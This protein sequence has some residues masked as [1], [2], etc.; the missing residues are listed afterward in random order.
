MRAGDRRNVTKDDREIVSKLRESLLDKVGKERFELW[1][2]DHV[3][4]DYSKG[5]LC[6]MAPD[7]FT[8]QRL[9]MKLLADIRDCADA[10]CGPQTELRLVVDAKPKEPS[11]LSNDQANDQAIDNSSRSVT[12]VTGGAAGEQPSGSQDLAA[13][14]PKLAQTTFA[15]RPPASDIRTVP[16]RR[17]ATLRDFAV[18]DSNRVAYAAAQSVLNRL[19]LISPLFL[20][21]PSGCGKTH[22]GEAI[23]AAARERGVRRAVILQSELFTSH[24]LEALHDSGLPNFRRK[25]RD[26]ELIFVDDVQ[27]FVGKKATLIEFQHTLDML[28]RAGGQVILTADR[29]P[30]ELFGLGPEII[31]R[32]S[33]GLVCGLQPAEYSTRLG[34]LRQWS[35]RRQMEVPMEVLELMAAELIGDARQLSGALHRIQATSEA[36]Q[37]PITAELA[38][39]C[40]SDLFRVTKRIVRLAD[41]QRAVCQ[42]FGMDAKTLQTGGK[43]RTVSQPRMLAMWLARKYTRAALTEIGQFF[44]RRSHTSVLAAQRK[45]D[46]L[47]ATQATI[48]LDQHQCQ[49]EDALRRI[50][51]QIRAG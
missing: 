19:G 42:V 34:I 38:R 6:V 25:Y 26:A 30:A 37:V 8:L 3:R 29:P 2:G 31:A 33:S 40:L 27:F 47:V 43:S 35:A 4:F 1:F 14:R 11:A 7:S 13:A 22:L 10:V 49:V 39:Q 9:R 36:L 45:V 48:R 5:M 46:Q 18:G 16:R 20:F 15:F 50:E 32:M 12:G 44:G 23:I 41:I 51:D 17:L 21:G 28:Q 24:F